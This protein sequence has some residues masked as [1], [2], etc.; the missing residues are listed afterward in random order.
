MPPDP[1]SLAR[2]HMHT[3]TSDTHVTPPFKILATGLK[4]I[5][6]CSRSDVLCLYMDPFSYTS[7]VGIVSITVP[8]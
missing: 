8:S 4:V 2:L 6:I 7:G 5:N 1:P 3:F